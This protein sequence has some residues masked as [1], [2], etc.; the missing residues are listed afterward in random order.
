M[1]L[2]QVG[3]VFLLLT[4]NFYF[5]FLNYTS[6]VWMKNNTLT[7]NLLKTA[8]IIQYKKV[9]Q[10]LELPVFTYHTPTV[11]TRAVFLV[12]CS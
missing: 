10:T 11:T 3:T 5:Y 4:I 1:Q 8:A 2:S 12:R 9:Q 7:L 6:G